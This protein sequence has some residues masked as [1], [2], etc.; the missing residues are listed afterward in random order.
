[1][2]VRSGK[3]VGSCR[4][5]VQEKSH[6]GHAQDDSL[7]EGTKRQT[8]CGAGQLISSFQ[9]TGEACMGELSGIPVSKRPKL[10]HWPGHRYIP[11]VLQGV[12][13]ELPIRTQ[14]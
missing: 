1:M 8:T 12:F 10:K 5:A 7:E 11:T 6:T 4:S 14:G 9:S 13:M 2:P 3:G